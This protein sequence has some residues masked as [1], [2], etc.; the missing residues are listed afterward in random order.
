L[1]SNNHR[2]R[3][4]IIGAGTTKGEEMKHNWKDIHNEWCM[5]LSQFIYDES[6]SCDEETFKKYDEM[7]DRIGDLIKEQADLED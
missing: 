4:E 5:T 1:K 2:P 6:R 3:S 7:S